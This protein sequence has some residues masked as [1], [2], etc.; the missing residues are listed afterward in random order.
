MRTMS[1][2]LM[3]VVICGV[4]MGTPQNASAQSEGIKVHGDWV[5][6]VRESNGTL[7]SHHEFKN[8]LTTEGKQLLAALLAGAPSERRWTVSMVGEFIREISCFGFMSCTLSQDANSLTI[9]AEGDHFVL[10]GQATMDST[11]KI[12]MVGTSVTPC[13]QVVACPPYSFTSKNFDP[14]RIAVTAGQIVQVKIVISF[15]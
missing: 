3:V 2:V 6:D 9:A 15:S 14:T 5:I 8:A 11:G 10:T 12:W 13:Q 1:Q 7:V 4:A